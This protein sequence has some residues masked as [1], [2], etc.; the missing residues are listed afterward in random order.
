MLQGSKTRC[1]IDD[2]TPP[3]HQS[4]G[5][6]EGF[7]AGF[8]LRSAQQRA[9]VAALGGI[10]SAGH[11]L[12]ERKR[13]NFYTN[14]KA[15]IRSQKH[16]PQPDGFIKLKGWVSI[17]TDTVVNF[18]GVFIASIPLQATFCV[19]SVTHL[20]ERRGLGLSNS[21]SIEDPAVVLCVSILGF[22]SHTN[23]F[24]G[25]PSLS[26]ISVDKVTPR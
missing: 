13:H 20:A 26:A 5:D 2:F 25:M 22:L 21:V 7:A 15:A 24:P 4:S 11:R 10:A 23:C 19:N 17:P 9:P 6:G 3:I 18:T 12:S 14:T 1:V 16:I 8:P